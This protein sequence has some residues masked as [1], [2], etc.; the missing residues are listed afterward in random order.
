MTNL[1]LLPQHP[2]LKWSLG[3]E[4]EFFITKYSKTAQQN[5]RK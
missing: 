5:I 3:I 1:L 4:L 2:A